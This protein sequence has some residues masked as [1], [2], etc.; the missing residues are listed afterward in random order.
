MAV[1]QF[2]PDW[3][4][5]FK[6][7]YDYKTEIIESRRGNEQ[8]VSLRE[9][10]RVTYDFTCNLSERDYRTAASVILQSYDTQI[11]M[12]IWNRAT[13]LTASIGGTAFTT[14][15]NESSIFVGAD[16]IFIWRSLLG[17]VNQVATVATKS[18]KNITLTA[19]PSVTIP[20][21][22]VLYPMAKGHLSAS[23]KTSAI[24][25]RNGVIS[26]SFEVDPSFEVMRSIPTA[27][28]TYD[29]YELIL[30]EPNWT[31]DVS[32]EYSTMMDTL[33]YG[34]GV[35]SFYSPKPFN[36]RVTTA[37]Y[38]GASR[39]EVNALIDIYRRAR[40]RLGE[41]YMPT[42]VEDMRLTEPL[43][44]GHR[45]LTMYGGQGLID[46]DLS[47]AFTRIAII[48]MD[49]TVETR[50]VTDIDTGGGVTIVTLD[51]DITHDVSPEDVN[52]ICWLP[53]CRFASD[54]LV[55]EWI[56]DSVG[57]VGFTTK[58]LEALSA[59]T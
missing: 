41:F 4:S 40:G 25:D 51:S 5:K 6:V 16:V 49:G 32:I 29:G 24:G 26:I 47:V 56:T 42:F 12:P 2:E 21:D 33:D 35:K 50:K 34:V 9:V 30:I 19:A 17:T 3:A 46:F 31:N 44:A 57:E 18:G 37:T 7:T 45:T 54:T 27:P 11:S 15:T 8:R 36:D 23:T 55:V 28:M 20:A 13:R 58:M 1:W 22:A 48:Y 38:L 59:E 10:P 52:M 53:L 43:T 14:E 39:D